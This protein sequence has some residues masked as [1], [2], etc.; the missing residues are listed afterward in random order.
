MSKSARV[1]P[2]PSPSLRP[3]PKS[4]F[5]LQQRPS[6]GARQTDRPGST[7]AGTHELCNC[8]D[9]TW[10]LC[11]VPRLARFVDRGQP[12]P[13]GSTA[14]GEGNCRQLPQQLP[15]RPAPPR[16][17]HALPLPAPH[18]PPRGSDHPQADQRNDLDAQAKPRASGKMGL[19]QETLGICS[20][21]WTRHESLNKCPGKQKSD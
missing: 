19:G 8:R 15:P 14:G 5:P 4:L 21:F 3:S 18:R 2:F 7:P 12:R 6:C 17:A 9:V 10:P 16:P 20:L 13:R 1:N 11:L